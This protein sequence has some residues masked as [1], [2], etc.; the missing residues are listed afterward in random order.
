MCP[1]AGKMKL[2]LLDPLRASPR[3]SWAGSGLGCGLEITARCS[4]C[5]PDFSADGLG[6]KSGLGH[7]CALMPPH[8]Q[9]AQRVDCFMNRHRDVRNKVFRG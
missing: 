1:A 6:W 4:L 5:I 8:P 2:C 3:A 7:E 9:T